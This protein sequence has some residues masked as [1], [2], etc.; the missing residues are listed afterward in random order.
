M[1]FINPS[2]GDRMRYKRPLLSSLLFL[3]LCVTRCIHVTLHVA[4]HLLNVKKKKWYGYNTYTPNGEWDDVTERMLRSFTEGGHPVFRGTSAFERSTFRSKGGEKLSFHFCGGPLTV[5]VVSRPITS[6]NKLSIYGAV[7][8]MCEELA[9]RISDYLV[10]TAKLVAE[11]K[12]ET[13]VSP[14]NLSTTTNPLLTCDWA[15]RKLDARIRTKI[16]KSSR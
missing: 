10:G 11:D 14:T 3:L 5:E 16:R 4:L 15:R 6:F 1:Q 7:A 8:D 12:P 2:L 9:S 13:T